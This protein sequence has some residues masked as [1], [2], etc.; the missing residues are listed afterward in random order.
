MLSDCSVLK[1]PHVLY[2]SSISSI[3]Y[4]LL[5]LNRKTKAIRELK[6]QNTLYICL[7]LH[8]SFSLHDHLSFGKMKTL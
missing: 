1:L 2:R 3:H 6:K 7:Q 5:I 8:D 4:Y